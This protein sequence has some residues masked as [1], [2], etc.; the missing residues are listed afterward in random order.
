MHAAGVLIV[1]EPAPRPP[2][3]FQEVGRNRTRRAGLIPRVGKGVAVEVVFGAAA[4]ASE[5]TH[6][7]D[8]DIDEVRSLVQAMQA[9]LC[10]LGGGGGGGGEDAG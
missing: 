6:T 2:D 10:L 1:D 7:P 5:R 4:S 9:L 3:A 8:I